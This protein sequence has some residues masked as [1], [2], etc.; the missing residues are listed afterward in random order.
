MSFGQLKDKLK[1]IDTTCLRIDSTSKT[2]KHYLYLSDDP[3]YLSG[4]WVDRQVWVKYAIDTANKKSARIIKLEKKPITF[5]YSNFKLIKLT[6]KEIRSDTISK[7]ADY[8]FENWKVL[9]KQDK[10]VLV[11]DIRPLIKEAKD[12]NILWLYR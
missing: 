1:W 9:A 10:S 3:L 4:K 2:F 6:V 7:Q 5:Y 8:Y 12:R 11:R